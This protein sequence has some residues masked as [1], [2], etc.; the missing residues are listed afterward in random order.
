MIFKL[1]NKLS[2]FD[3]TPTL[4]HVSSSRN[5]LLVIVTWI[6]L[7]YTTL[8]M[9]GSR[10]TEK[11]YDIRTSMLTGHFPQLGDFIKS[12]TNTPLNNPASG[13]FNS[14]FYESN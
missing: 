13:G 10:G 7:R 9:A 11:V 2:D 6:K 4:L 8:I 14:S 1:S 5:I 12:G 3:N